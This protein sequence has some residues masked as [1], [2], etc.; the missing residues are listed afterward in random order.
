MS[1][2]T[3]PPPGWW[4]ASDGRWYPPERFT[5]REAQRPRSQRLLGGLTRY[6]LVSAALAFCLLAAVTGLGVIASAPTNSDLA[7]M[8]GS[9]VLQAALQAATGQG[10]VEV[11]QQI[12]AFG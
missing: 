8:S 10:A 11:S 1:V 9:Q 5:G 12:S 7:G 3:Q 2:G 6:Q 4:L